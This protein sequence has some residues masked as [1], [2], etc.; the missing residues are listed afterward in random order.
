MT[1]NAEATQYTA[2]LDSAGP[3]LHRECALRYRLPFARAIAK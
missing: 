3:G 2:D 1:V